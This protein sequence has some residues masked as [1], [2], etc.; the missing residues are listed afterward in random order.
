MGKVEGRNL[1]SKTSC[2]PSWACVRI[3]EEK[4]IT[5]VSF[6]LKPLRTGKKVGWGWLGRV[7]HSLCPKH[8]LPAYGILIFLNLAPPYP[9]LEPGQTPAPKT[10]PE[11]LQLGEESLSSSPC[12]W[13]TL[14]LRFKISQTSL[15][16]AC[17]PPPFFFSLIFLFLN[18]FM[19]V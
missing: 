13:G 6:S 19:G 14:C 4:E 10:L 8:T 18:S 7:L 5:A 17:Q 12:A 15:R 11:S 2:L 3:S 16:Y 9:D 1:I